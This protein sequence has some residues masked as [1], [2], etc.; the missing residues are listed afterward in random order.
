MVLNV[1]VNIYT[2]MTLRKNYT[3]IPLLKLPKYI[4]LFDIIQ[5]ILRHTDAFCIDIIIAHTQ[6]WGFILLNIV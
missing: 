4:F 1:H 5:C 2:F 6:L 3:I